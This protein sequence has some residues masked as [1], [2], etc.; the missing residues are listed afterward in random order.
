MHHKLNIKKWTTKSCPFFML[1][2]SFIITFIFL[3]GTAS[4]SVPGEIVNL[5]TGAGASAG[6]YQGGFLG[7]N[8]KQFG[9]RVTLVD[10]QTG[11][12]TPP[13][14][15]GAL[16]FGYARTLSSIPLPSGEGIL[17]SISVIA[18][19]DCSENSMFFLSIPIASAC[20][21]FDA[22]ICMDI[23]AI[24]ISIKPNLLY[25]FLYFITFHQF[26]Q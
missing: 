9:A 17:S 19:M 7:Y 12:K 2:I 21:V 20:C 8:R 24:A 3:A 26:C 6:S 14:Y 23:D 1:L 13:N 10:A 11:K 4:A 15:S 25:R 18:S 22:A 5:K 16:S